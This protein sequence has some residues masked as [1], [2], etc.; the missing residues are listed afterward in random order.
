MFIKRAAILYTRGGILEG[1]SYG[2]I[3]SLAHRMGLTSTSMYGYVDS[4]D[5]FIDVYKATE[6]AKAAGQ[7]P[8]DFKGTIAPEDLFGYPE[9]DNAVD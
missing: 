8:E 6:I 3:V 1:K 5:N 9:D 4:S 2:S 7:V